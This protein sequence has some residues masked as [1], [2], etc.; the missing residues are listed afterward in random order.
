MQAWEET[1]GMCLRALRPR[2]W[3]ALWYVADGLRNSEIAEHMSLAENTVEKYVTS[4][5]QKL[6]LPSRST[7]LSYI[8]THQLDVLRRLSDDDNPFATFPSTS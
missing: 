4:I 5:L 8:I 3:E 1:T 6:S 2:E 7:L